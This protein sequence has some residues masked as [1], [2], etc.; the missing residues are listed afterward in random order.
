M[1]G[2][3]FRCVVE[4]NNNKLMND[5]VIAWSHEEATRIFESRWNHCGF[6]VKEVERVCLNGLRL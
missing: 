6:N 3:L 2:L 5:F 4:E 1:Q